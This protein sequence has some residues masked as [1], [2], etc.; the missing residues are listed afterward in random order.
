MTL[1]QFPDNAGFIDLE[2]LHWHILGTTPAENGSENH[3][4]DP[5]NLFHDLYRDISYSN[6]TL[7]RDNSED[8]RAASHLT[9]TD[10]VDGARI[11][12]IL[13]AQPLQ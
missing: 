1:T 2:N 6:N 4:Q 9:L 13:S 10:I 11:S 12:I 5:H 8:G 7:F 3:L